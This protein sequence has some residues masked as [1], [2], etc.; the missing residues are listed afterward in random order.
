[1]K[2]EE[3]KKSNIDTGFIVNVLIG[4]VIGALSTV[5]LIMIFA[6]VLAFTDI[7]EATVGFFGYLSVIAGGIIGGLISSRRCGRNGLMSGICTGLMMF[8]ILFI[9][10][11]F[12]AN[13]G[14]L[15]INT[16]F[17]LFAM[18]ISSAFGGIAGVNM[19]WKKRK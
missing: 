9:V 6:A 18:L 17:M 19:K 13:L 5:L 1:M 14:S 7:P 15:T 4:S 3:A 16:I 2:I 10:R 11:M 8:I 12:F